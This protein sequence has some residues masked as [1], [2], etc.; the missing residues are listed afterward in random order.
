MSDMTV[1]EAALEAKLHKETI[2]NALR[3]GSLHGYQRAAGRSDWRVSAP[4]LEAW[5]HG[6]PCAHQG[7]LK[8]AA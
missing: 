3:S 1:V 8:V 5:G 6:T 2:R 4:C 7:A